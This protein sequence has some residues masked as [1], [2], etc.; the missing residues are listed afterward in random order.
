MKKW[1]HAS[2]TLIV[3]VGLLI[4]FTAAAASF[5]IAAQLP[6]DNHLMRVILVVCGV[7]VAIFGFAK[8]M[9]WLFV[10]PALEA[11]EALQ[12]KAIT[13]QNAANKEF[14]RDAIAELGK[15]FDL[16]MERH[17]LSGDPHPSASKRMHGELERADVEILTELRDLRNEQ[18]ASQKTLGRLVRAHNA[19]MSMERR[20][21][22]TPVCLA[23]RDPSDSPF[24]RR[25][26]DDPDADFSK[27]RGHH[28]VDRMVVV[29][30][31]EEKT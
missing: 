16:L 31:D 2:A 6:P 5:Q 3:L 15:G 18:R 8:G 27:K 11:W 13:E 14:L 29:E 25:E 26:T 28:A 4:P 12:V 1:R 9:N 10:R 19:A 20:E 17:I 22:G 30:D 24:P 21:S 7:V 23:A